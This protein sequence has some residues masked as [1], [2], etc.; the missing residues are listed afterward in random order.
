MLSPTRAP[1]EPTIVLNPAY[2]AIAG[3]RQEGQR[4]VGRWNANAKLTVESPSRRNSNIQR[5]FSVQQARPQPEPII[6]EDAKGLQ[7][8]CAE[9]A[10]ERAF[11][12][13]TEFVM[14]DCFDPELCL[15]QIATSQT[16]TIIDPFA[17]LD[18]APVWEL[19]CDGKVET[20]VHA[21]QEDFGLCAQHCGQ[22]PRNIFDVQIAAGLVGPDYPLSLQK[23]VQSTIHIR[24]HKAK[25]LTDWRKRPLAADQIRYAA[26]DVGHLIEVRRVL[27]KRLAGLGRTSW[28]R[29]EFK[30]FEELSLYDRDEEDKLRRIKGSGSLGGKQLS[31]L[32]ELLPWRDK[33]AETRNRPARTVV[34]DHL[35]VEIAKLGLATHT[36]IR[37]LRGVNLSGRDIAALCRVVQSG[38]DVPE[39]QWP[40]KTPRDT[41]SAGEAA[42]SALLTAVLR[43]YCA[44]EGLAYSLVATK[45]SIRELIRHR[46][47]K[48]SANTQHVELL[49][50]W[51]G[52]AVGN[53]LDDILAGRRLLRV[54][55][56]NGQPSVDVV[57][58]KSNDDK[59]V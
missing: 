20:I 7:R 58:E 46:M 30:A 42:L 47:R 56:A 49:H 13:D 55:T 8:V 43:S 19:V 32:R 51:R 21:G 52:Q 57:D 37:D 59:G 14:E 6:V 41:E 23:L 25:T 3:I 29:A 11:A 33:L 35:L 2:S 24:L 22:A 17:D 16:V 48:R 39:D 36:E 27:G 4:K 44:R 1:A 53:M 54:G 10:S 40:Q 38:M 34:R 12:F 15:V 31:I 9:M 18:L 45:K 50:S 5:E 28:A 26:E